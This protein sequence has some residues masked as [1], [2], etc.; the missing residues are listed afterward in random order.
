MAG[1][2]Y[3]QIY[4]AI[5]DDLREKKLKVG[6]VIPSE[7]ELSIRLNANNRTVRRAFKELVSAGIVEKRFRSGT[8]L[9]ESLE[10][11]WEDAPLNLVLFPHHDAAIRLVIRSARQIAEEYGR[12]LNI[13]YA[14]SSNVVFDALHA[15]RRYHQ[16]TIIYC[17]I[18][19]A[20]MAELEADPLNFVIIGQI[21]EKIPYVRCDDRRAMHLAFEHLR[22]LGHRR[23]AYCSFCGPSGSSRL[24]AEQVEFWKSELG[25]DYA[26]E[27]Q[28]DFSCPDDEMELQ[29]CF[30][31]SML[32]AVGK[33][34][35]SAVISPLGEI[36]LPAQIA[37]RDSGVLVPRDCSMVAVS[38]EP[39]LKYCVSPCT[40]VD[41]DIAEHVRHAYRLLEHNHYHPEAAEYSHIVEPRLILRESTEKLSR[42]FKQ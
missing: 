37:L 15:F 8:Y 19:P 16:P 22:R 29:D 7:R 27:L 36:V 33:V 18:A 40:A 2:K 4:Q 3:Q 1:Y 5:I 39:C 30:Y 25:D 41:Q 17:D 35:F 13:T 34:A 38:Y 31:R 21:A 10:H 20:E 24:A 23:I 26:P 14:V 9:K 28:L 32:E 6:D 12:S 11:S 42:K